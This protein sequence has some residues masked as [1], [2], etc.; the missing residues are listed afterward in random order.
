MNKDNKPSK[1]VFNID[2]VRLNPDES[3][4]KR[5]NRVEQIDLSDQT[6]E[7]KIVIFNS[8][9]YKRQEIVSIRVN[10][11]NVQVFAKDRVKLKNVQVNLVWANMDGGYLKD[12][13]NSGNK[14]KNMDD[15]SFASDFDQQYYEVLFEA[16][17]DSLSFTTFTISKKTA[18]KSSNSTSPSIITDLTK[19]VYYYK[20]LND[21]SN[22]ILKEKLSGQK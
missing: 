19:V 10:T 21:D 6:P 7:Q 8:N 1:L 18:D 11:P 15:Y 14:I 13:L 12:Y 4:A 3:S 20:T 22:K 2:D 9:L 17:L 5:Q 16:S